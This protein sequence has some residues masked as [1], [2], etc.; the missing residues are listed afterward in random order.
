[1]KKDCGYIVIIGG[2]TGVGKTT[3]TT[4]LVKKIPNAI[5]FVTTTT[6]APRAREKHGRD[7]FFITKKTFQKKIKNNEFF[8]YNYYENRDDYYGTD[9]KR[10][11][12]LLDSGKIVFFILDPNG[13]R[14]FKKHFKQRALSILLTPGKF[15]DLIAHIKK[16]NPKITEKELK[17]R[18]QNAK[19]ESEMNKKIYDYTVKNVHG[20]MRE[21]IDRVEKLIQKHCQ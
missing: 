12:K 5:R 1:M 16:R 14:F 10:L 3:I 4:R 18:I 6:R 19:D 21:T 11:Q 2:P 20:K 8:E 7:Y 13:V 15:N 9:K 17:Q